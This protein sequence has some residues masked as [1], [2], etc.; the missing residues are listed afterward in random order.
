[1]FMYSYACSKKYAVIVGDAL[2]QII[3]HPLPL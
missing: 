2:S 1:L 3:F